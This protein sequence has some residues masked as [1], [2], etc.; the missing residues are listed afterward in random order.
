MSNLPAPV[1]NNMRCIVHNCENHAHEG[2]GVVPV[3]DGTPHFICGPCYTF[4]ITSTGIHSQ[5]YRNSNNGQQ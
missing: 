2:A 5:L 3:M 4:L 1:Q